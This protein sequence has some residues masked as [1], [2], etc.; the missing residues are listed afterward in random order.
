[1]NDQIYTESNQGIVYFVRHDVIDTDMLVKR[2]VY[3]DN[4]P[5]E[6]CHLVHS[7]ESYRY[8]QLSKPYIR[9]SY[10]PENTDI[11]MYDLIKS[12]PKDSAYR[13]Q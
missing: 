7:V 6:I 4:V 10:I 8:N 2:R 5:V 11:P 9:R 12:F 3:P 1:M 13:V